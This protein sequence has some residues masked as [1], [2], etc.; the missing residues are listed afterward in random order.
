MTERAPVTYRDAGVDID[1][2]EELVER[3]KPGVRRSM[4]P[5]SAGRHRRLRGVG[6]SALDRYRKAGC[7]VRH[8]RGGHQNTSRIDTGRHDTVGIDLSPCVSTTS[9]FKAPSRFLPGLFRHRK[10]LVDSVRGSLPDRRRVRAGG[11]AWWGR[12]CE[13]P[14]M[15]H[16]DDYDLRGFC[17]GIVEKDPS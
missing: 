11:L 4:T 2:G 14:G 6:R 15:Y 17:V 13:M 9:W 10:A 12:N 8:R 3:I 7:G 16:G 5:R 1:A